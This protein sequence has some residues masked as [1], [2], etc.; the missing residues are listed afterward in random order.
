VLEGASAGKEIFDKGELAAILR[1]G[2]ENLFE[3]DKDDV[4]IKEEVKKRD[5]QLYE[6][7]IDAI[8]ARAEV[9]DQRV[10]VRVPSFLTP[11]ACARY[12]AIRTTV[13]CCARRSGF[14]WHEHMLQR[15]SGCVLD[16]R[17]IL[18]DAHTSNAAL[19]TINCSTGSTSGGTVI[20]EEAEEKKNELLSAFN[21]ATFKNKEDDATFW[22]R[23]ITD[24]Q[25]AAAPDTKK[26][27]ASAGG[28]DDLAPRHPRRSAAVGDNPKGTPHVCSRSACPWSQP[29]FMLLL[30]MLRRGSARFAPSA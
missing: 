23:L 22:N 30:G 11:L 14:C 25:R 3:E 29:A 7:D 1:F 10:Q 24:E 17:M 26:R 2:A 8:L 5:Q 27:K 19:L 18:W 13:L 21:V 28:D 20:Q 4:Q 6:E 16:T 9:V 12:P 15:S